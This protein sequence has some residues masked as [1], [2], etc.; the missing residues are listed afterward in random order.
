MQ[1][2][3]LGDAEAA[4]SAFAASGAAIACL[5]A[6]DAGYA[7]L[8][9]ASTAALK[10][11]GARHVYLAGRPK[12][13]ETALTAAGVDGFIFAGGDALAMLAELHKA[14]GIADV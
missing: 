13:L 14:L 5:C 10:S 9:A 2:E 8:G 6:A 12:D 7:E 11:A 1:S 3:P 4:A